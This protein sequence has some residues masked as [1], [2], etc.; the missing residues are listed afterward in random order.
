M[1]S[2]D[3]KPRQTIEVVPVSQLPFCCMAEPNPKQALW[4]WSSVHNSF[5]APCIICN[6][7]PPRLYLAWT[8][9]AVLNVLQRPSGQLVMS[10]LWHVAIHTKMLLTGIRGNACKIDPSESRATRH[11][12]DHLDSL[13]NMLTAARK[14]GGFG[15]KE[16]PGDCVLRLTA[17]ATQELYQNCVHILWD[18]I[19]TS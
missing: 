16:I 1:F 12:Q 9:T 8:K 11:A 10:Q 2:S 18:W 4:F 15:G 5:R 19:C 6:G 7:Q 17:K 14:P 13:L 3:I